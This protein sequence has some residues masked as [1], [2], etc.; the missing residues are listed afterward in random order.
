VAVVAIQVSTCTVLNATIMNYYPPAL[1]G[2][3]SSKEGWCWSLQFG[4][5]KKN[6]DLHPNRFDNQTLT[7]YNQLLRQTID[8]MATSVAATN[9][10]EILVTAVMTLL[11]LRLFRFF[12]LQPRLAVITH[13]IMHAAPDLL[14][15]LFILSLLLAGFAAIGC[16]LWGM[17]LDAFSSF[18]RSGLTMFFILMGSFGDYYED[19]EERNP[20]AAP[21][22]IVV[23]L[24]LMVTLAMNILLAILVDAYEEVCISKRCVRCTICKSY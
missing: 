2:L 19:M 18:S 1:D 7:E 5:M 21:V 17:A 22:F 20:I 14:H 23:Y 11:L 16:F 10:V 6:A 24:M 15:F 3:D 8:P 9:H 4:D 12:N 13:T